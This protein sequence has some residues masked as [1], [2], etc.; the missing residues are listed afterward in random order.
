MDWE[1]DPKR[2]VAYVS[3]HTD[4]DC[5]KKPI[6]K[7]P[8]WFTDMT[9]RGKTVSSID[10]VLAIVD[11]IN[12]NGQDFAC[13]CL[14]LSVDPCYWQ[15]YEAMESTVI[16]GKTELS[17]TKLNVPTPFKVLYESDAWISKI[18]PHTILH[19]TNWV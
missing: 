9:N 4:A 13:A 12:D 10:V 16:S 8:Q 15:A 3:G 7:D 2:N 6:E 14:C 1:L 18:G 5:W 17:T 11:T 19:T